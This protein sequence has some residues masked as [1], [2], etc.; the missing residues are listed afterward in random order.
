MNQSLDVRTSFRAQ[1]VPCREL[2]SPF[3]ARLCELLAERLAGDTVIGEAILNWPGDPSGSGDA[4]ALRLCGALHALVVGE[5]SP[6][7]AAVYPPNHQNISD[8][9]LW[10]VLEAAL[11]KHAA[12]VVERLKS[13]PQTN[14]VRRSAILLPG[15][16]QITRQTGLPMVLSELGA[17]AGL[18]LHWDRFYY[19]IGDQF[20]GEAAS[21][22]KLCPDWQGAPAALHAVEVKSRA[23][24]DLNP[25][26]VSEPQNCKRLLSYIWPDQSERISRTRAAM[27]I[28]VASGV[29]VEKA[30][31]IDWLQQRLAQS[32]DGAVHVIYHTIA[33]QYFPADVQARGRALMK[34]AGATARKGAPIAWLRFEMDGKKPGA[35][36]TLT[37]WPSGEECHLARADFHGRWIDWAGQII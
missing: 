17:S 13:A 8:D 23:G 32:H 29:T 20:W 19:Q 11:E 22:V 1:A 16:C 15:F 5:L 34:A 7:L 36:L 25:L 12:F 27:E 4:L 21:P 3:T 2:G 30:D 10:L 6:E 18:N 37:M 24:C 9:E 14:E 35:A 33:W 31:A 26:D 28:A